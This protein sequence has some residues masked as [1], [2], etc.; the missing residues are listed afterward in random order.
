MAPSVFLALNPFVNCAF[1][2]PGDSICLSDGKDHSPPA[3][4]VYVCVDYT[5]VAGDT[6]SS[7]AAKFAVTLQ[8]FTTLNKNIACSPATSPIPPGT[9]LCP[10]LIDQ[11]TVTPAGWVCNKTVTVK[12]HD[13]CFSISKA[14]S[15]SVVQLRYW[16]DGLNC[17]NLVVGAVVC[18]GMGPKTAPPSTCPCKYTVSVMGA[19]TTIDASVFC[20]CFLA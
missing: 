8:Q 13:T 18:I 14:A 15:I 10:S 20:C 6:C 12:A 2:L 11:T 19:S 4:P 17:D 7:V 1:L 9:K 16:N 5:S 3:A